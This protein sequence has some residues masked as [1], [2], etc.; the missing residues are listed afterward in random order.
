VPQQQTTDF[1]PLA[2][3]ATPVPTPAASGS[4][5]DEFDP[6]KFGATLVAP[7]QPEDQDQGP[8]LW[9]RV[10][11]SVVE[12]MEEAGAASLKWTK[13]HPFLAAGGP[14]P[15]LLLNPGAGEP[16]IRPE[17]ADTPEER[18]RHPYMTAFGEAAG[19]LTSPRNI[20]IMLGT[21]GLGAAGMLPKLVS[22]YF[23]SSMV[24][25]YLTQQA[26][27]LA[28]AIDRQDW[29]EVK[30]IGTSSA[31]NLL[32]AGFGA[33]HMG[34]D[35]S[36][37]EAPAG[38]S[39]DPRVM[40]QQRQRTQQQVANR[41]DV[42]QRALHETMQN[43][44]RR[45]TDQEIA[46]LR[47]RVTAE[48]ARRAEDAEA[49]A[50]E[51][52][53][54]DVGRREAEAPPAM[55]EGRPVPSIPTLE[56][57]PLTPDQKFSQAE[58]EAWKL[59]HEGR[60]QDAMHLLAL[61]DEWLREQPEARDQRFKDQQAGEMKRLED[62]AEKEE[63]R[64]A[65]ERGFRDLGRTA[66]ERP[67]NAVTP[68][69]VAVTPPPLEPPTGIQPPPAPTAP[70]VRP[71]AVKE[72]P[73]TAKIEPPGTQ[74]A[75]AS[76]PASWGTA[77]E[78]VTPQNTRIDFQYAVVPASAVRTSFDANFKANPDYPMELQPRDR[79]RA[80]SQDQFLSLTTPGESQLD[81]LRM[82]ESPNAGDGAPI[83]GTDL[84]AETRNMGTTV[85][86]TLYERNSPIADQY[87]EALIQNA[88]RFGLDP[89]QVSQL[90]S[91]VLV[92]V[93]R[94]PMSMDQ[95]SDFAQEANVPTTA[96]MAAS[97]VAKLDSQKLDQRVLGLLQ[98]TSDGSVNNAANADFV[99]QFID[100][101]VSP[102]ER[103]AYMRPD[104]SLSLEGIN[105]I[106]N[107]LFSRA[108]P[109]ADAIVE[110]MAESADSNIRNVQNAMHGAA[111]K[112]AI[113]QEMIDRGVLYDFGIT[114]DIGD[115]AKKLSELRKSGQSVEDFLGQS[116]LPGFEGMSDSAKE[117]LRAI[118]E[119]G[120]SVK[121][122]TQILS[123]YADAAMSRGRIDQGNIFGAGPVVSKDD[124]LRAV[125]RQN[126]MLDFGDEPPAPV[127]TVPP[128]PRVQAPVETLVPPPRAYPASTEL[129]PTRAQ[130]ES[131][132]EQLAE[133]K[134]NELKKIL[135]EGIRR[136]DGWEEVYNDIRARG[137]DA[138]WEH[139]DADDLV[140]LAE[141]FGYHTEGEI[142]PEEVRKV[143]DANS[144]AV[145]DR[146]L[147]AYSRLIV[148][149]R[150]E[151]AAIREFLQTSEPA[152]AIAKE[153]EPPPAAPVAQ[154]TEQMAE[155][156]RRE[157]E[158]IQR[159]LENPTLTAAER[160]A[161]R[162]RVTERNK[163][164][165]E[166]ASRSEERPA[167]PQA[168]KAAKKG[169]LALVGVTA[170]GREDI[171][172]QF[173]KEFLKK[174][175]DKIVTTYS[176]GD[177]PYML[178]DDQGKVIAESRTWQL[179][180]GDLVSAEKLQT[181]SDVE[182][183]AA[184]DDAR[185]RAA[186]VQP[187]T[188]NADDITR[189]TSNIEDEVARRAAE[190]PN[191]KGFGEGNT[192]VTKDRGE[193]LKR[194]LL[195]KLGGGTL[196]SGLDPELL[197]DL[198]EYGVYL[199]EGGVREIA[200]W[201]AAM[202]KTFGEA[203]RPY[204]DEV[205]NKVAP[206]ARTLADNKK[207]I[208]D[209][210]L[211][212]ALDKNM[213]LFG[214]AHPTPEVED[215]TDTGRPVGEAANEGVANQGR[216]ATPPPLEP[217]AKPEVR[218][219]VVPREPGDG[220][221]VGISRS[222]KR[223]D[224]DA[225]SLVRGDW[226]VAPEAWRAEL[227]A[228]KLPETAPGPSTVLSPAVDRKLIYR[229]Q[230]PIVEMAVSEIEHGSG[231]FVI[232]S[233]TGTGKTVMG[234]A[235]VKEFLDRN[236]GQQFVISLT[237]NDEIARAWKDWY[238]EMGI[239]AMKMPAGTSTP[240]EP[241]VYLST[242]ATLRNRPGMENFPWNLAVYDE[243]SEMRNWQISKQGAM[244]RA[245][246]K[247]AERNLYLSATPFSSAI[248]LGY[249]EPLG[250]WRDQGFEKW[251][252]QF[253]VY[254]DRKTGLL[255]GGNAPL[256]LSQLREQLIQRGQYIN[257]DT[258]LTGHNFSVGVVPLA[259]GQWEDLRNID[260]TFKTAEDY[261]Q[262]RRQTGLIMAS[263]AARVNYMK[264]YLERTRL[265]Q[266]I[267]IMKKLDAAGF[268]VAVFSETMAE[269]NEIYNFLKPLDDAMEGR[270]SR[271]LPPLPGVFDAL[272]REFG[273]QVANIS[274]GGSK[275]QEIKDFNDNAVKHAYAT[276]AKGGMGVSLHDTKGDAPRAAIYLGPPWSGMLLQQGLGRIWRFGT[277]SD[278]YSI[279]LGSDSR[280]EF[281]TVTQRVLARLE[282]MHALVS[283]IDK[284]NPTI[285][286][287]RSIEDAADY[288][289]GNEDEQA[290][291]KMTQRADIGGIANYKD[292][293]IPN[294]ADYKGR[295]LQVERRDITPPPGVHGASTLYSGFDPIAA[296]RAARALAGEIARLGTKIKA[297][298][299][300]G[301]DQ[302][303]DPGDPDQRA[304]DMTVGT[305]SARRLAEEAF[306]GED[307][308]LR[309]TFT[310]AAQAAATNWASGSPGNPTPAMVGAWRGGAIDTLRDAKRNG[311][312]VG[313]T[314]K[315]YVVL[316]GRML[317]ANRGGDI[318]HQ[319]AYEMIPDYQVRTGNIA[320]PWE[321]R[322]M[323]IKNKY[324]L[325]KDD[326]SNLH[327]AVEGVQPPANDRVAAAVRDIRQLNA[328]MAE[329]TRK[330]GVTTEFFNRA[331]GR[332]AYSPIGEDPFYMPRY[333]EPGTFEP[334]SATRERI[335]QQIMQRDGVSLA[336]AESRMQKMRRDVPLAGT[337]ERAREYDI[338]GYR[339]DFNAFLQHV[340]ETG[341]VIARTQVFGQRREK[342]SALTSMVP[343][344]ADRK[345][346]ND[347]MDLLLERRPWER[348]PAAI[349]TAASNWTVLTKMTTSSVSAMSHW[350]KPA[351]YVNLSSFI[352]GLAETVVHYPQAL[353]SVIEVGALDRRV[354]LNMYR[355]M[356]MREESIG[357]KFLR[358]TGFMWIDSFGRALA[359]ATAESYLERYAL[360]KLIENPGDQFV[361]RIL[362][363]KFQIPEDMI[364]RAITD[365]A[366]TRDAT[367]R[368]GKAYSDLTMYTNDPTELPA[369]FRL[370]GSTEAEQTLSA[371][372]RTSLMLKSYIWKNTYL[373]HDALISEAK[374]L[375]FRPWV[376]FL[377]LAPAVG[378]AIQAAT[379]YARQDKER[380]AELFDSE[381]PVTKILRQ[382]AFGAAFTGAATALTSAVDALDSGRSFADWLAGPVIGDVGRTLQTVWHAVADP[383][384]AYMTGKPA[385]PI[386]T[387]GE[388][389]EHHLQSY[390]R[391]TF[392]P[393]RPLIPPPP[394]TKPKE[395]GP[396]HGA[397]EFN[398]PPKRHYKN[399]GPFSGNL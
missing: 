52:G 96:R 112:F 27:E 344:Q 144:A 216:G 316:N 202:A 64:I 164:A 322:A 114:Q 392:L 363:E 102:S 167:E 270:L 219:P 353:R 133:L 37:L 95:R 205:W 69:A 378:T 32:M 106:R 85:L 359:N 206:T 237:K 303:T 48:A 330:A 266:A 109:G 141:N 10:K 302:M 28:K 161:L 396:F 121:G 89:G 88:S 139:T 259:D 41:I 108:Y 242:Y 329:A 20:A 35:E 193:E 75:L 356:N 57:S 284:A 349:L 354:R 343:E 258:D 332:M 147:G 131:R 325:S 122:L 180:R 383:A 358:R 208:A 171:F 42:M 213:G 65:A 391:E 138:V 297:A 91:P 207:Q 24:K 93:R 163:M 4:G 194:K 338:P 236:P 256:K 210:P 17:Q 45:P 234:A 188:M 395:Q 310:D 260:A 83:V 350:V 126:S 130:V 90:D 196:Y 13:E 22:G 125:T 67:A 276:Y 320:G 277:N 387:Q 295:G 159:R 292:I 333:Y 82:S 215:G 191:A 253:G 389:L 296:A 319:I 323:D 372:A 298:F 286:S 72:P 283:G 61:Y 211:R 146:A 267:E 142:D 70:A 360:P 8:S 156:L 238:A 77:G 288:A 92:R 326:W 313:R 327:Y 18:A 289:L 398:P 186:R 71:G 178:V 257:L 366:W 185:A 5:Q 53:F 263:R 375:N 307:P 25:D 99:R 309:E 228:S 347:T 248:E 158:E 84:N 66:S 318:G 384:K 362:Q 174:N 87:R 204:L 386:F 140:G 274:G 331:T 240:S 291:D 149:A 243:A 268:K 46:D 200:A 26:P 33:Q 169:G 98:P 381:W 249:L 254:N 287:M 80:A 364:D 399:E 50:R 44:P 235:I 129:N 179:R 397:G 58:E 181:M 184:L 247:A 103:G 51:Q 56:G 23:A 16:L 157:N 223:L 348:G 14:L 3:G 175:R 107:A 351:L 183:K 177:N 198:A 250:L 29:S 105:R 279:I 79:L 31:I 369:L 97:E 111:P 371:L 365:Q 221:G 355:E 135:K 324:N 374:K 15:E 379:A 195:G 335:V 68:P 233:S 341:E 212:D 261:F 280:A 172:R 127:P 293:A 290:A 246:G 1:N 38:L 11:A 94:T 382:A 7:A 36:K 218:A 334:G 272:Q 385:H 304:I 55:V 173:S 311:A 230:K 225:P 345:A 187:G 275:T 217:T 388:K 113:M 30:R 317:I 21:E 361:R 282:S 120:R 170:D 220:T 132:K 152:K 269:R 143:L 244:G 306:E 148:G 377:L 305:P 73:D 214:E 137:M 39:N 9:Q 6:L 264:A 49:Q 252:R 315:D 74:G 262:R 166:L 115:A 176:Q 314:I 308:S 189:A 155:T 47:A 59:V 62:E 255:G 168:F 63:E 86:K 367:A 54:R 34:M 227:K 231:S 273:D 117:L 370:K 380:M 165:E 251:A 2:Y 301:D 190:Q 153:L 368:A 104:G 337:V 118:N 182:L 101:V 203:V 136:T 151:G 241:G 357:S 265:P 154:S 312:D 199:V 12:P 229:P 346:I 393:L 76:A 239:E 124:I 245:L 352:H 110:Q 300:R 145:I 78:A 271:D 294:A 201:T 278:A 100:S 328:E 232:A 321:L 336:E 197:S 299:N 281:D 81:F 43:F 226:T 209:E 285:K 150:A 162:R 192:I 134:P 160:A 60:A 123:D 40:E 119:K 342:L 340:E 19:G 116:T 224:L 373:F 222:P 394:K 376:P 339:T 390:A 128:E